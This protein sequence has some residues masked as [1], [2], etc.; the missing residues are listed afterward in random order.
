MADIQQKITPFLWFDK[1]AKEAM[2]FYTSVFKDGK[3]ISVQYYPEGSQE[4]HM[5]GMEGKVLTG[6]FELA[7]QRFMA[8]DGGPLFK[9]N[10]SIS[11]YVECDGQEEVDYFWEKLSAVPESEQCGWLKDKFGVS[12]QIIPKQMGEI[13]S[14]PDAEKAGRAVH[15]MMQMGK[16]DL[17]KLQEAHDG[18]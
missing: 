18:K 7:G 16:I 5:K 17:A 4:E 14:S 9:F 12:W 11:F 15:A 2:E 10:E 1:E 13:L 6:V 8:L 3:I